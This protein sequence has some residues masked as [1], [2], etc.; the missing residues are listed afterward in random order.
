M[1]FIFEKGKNHIKIT[2][3]TTAAGKLNEKALPYG[4]DGPVFL[5]IMARNK[6]E[7]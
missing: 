6:E 5:D 1:G 2:V 7:K 4:I 3:Y